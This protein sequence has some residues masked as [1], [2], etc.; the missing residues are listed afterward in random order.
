MPYSTSTTY[1]CDGPECL[2][3]ETMPGYTRSGKWLLME[4]PEAGRVTFCSDACLREWAQRRR[5]LS[6]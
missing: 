2:K 5:W 3:I 4:H 6:A 1:D